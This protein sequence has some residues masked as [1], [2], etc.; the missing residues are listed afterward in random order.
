MELLGVNKDEVLYVGDSYIDA[1]TAVN[2]GVD[3][4]AVTTG[5][6]DKETFMRYPN[7]AIGGS[8][9]EALPKM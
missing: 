7:I 8:L 9:S 4:A 1:E 3:F 5:P 6:T 2:A